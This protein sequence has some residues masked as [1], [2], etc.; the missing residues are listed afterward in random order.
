MSR[1]L[2]RR[3]VLLAA[4]AVILSQR[5]KAWTH[6]HPAAAQTLIG[7]PGAFASSM[8]QFNPNRVP[9]INWS[10]PLTRG[11]LF[12]G[13]NV[14]GEYI[15][16]V[17]GRTLVPSVVPPIGAT[18]WDQGIAW[19]GLNNTINPGYGYV[20]AV[21]NDN[22]IH[23]AT[24]LKSLPAGAGYAFSTTFI[25]TATSPRSWIFGRPAQANENPPFVNYGFY[26]ENSGAADHTVT[27]AVNNNGTIAGVGTWDTGGYGQQS[28]L[29]CSAT[30]TSA[31]VA[32]ADFYANGTYISSLVGAQIADSGGVGIDIS[33]SFMFG[34][35]F[36]ITGEN[37]NQMVGLVPIGCFWGNPLQPREALAL[38]LN[39]YRFLTFN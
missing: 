37:A 14:G 19:N 32:T 31:G 39:P 38:T 13:Y 29:F 1:L 10:D 30:N 21:N 26:F 22:I 5:A 20:A 18:K 4:P 33:N 25:P 9:K 15:N 28:S 3:S 23:S 24:D 36:H 34:S 8:G 2:T 6:G 11:L 16:L 27:C 12:C 17:P 35:V 7:S